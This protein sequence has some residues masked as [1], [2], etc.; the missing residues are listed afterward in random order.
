MRNTAFRRLVRS[1]PT[2]LALA[3]ALAAAGSFIAPGVSLAEVVISP[4]VGV[5]APDA[6]AGVKGCYRLD[7]TIYGPY[8]MS[9]CLGG[10][11]NT[12]QVIGGGLNCAGNLDWYDRKDGKI[13]VDLHRTP[14]GK[15]QQWTGDSLTCKI[16]N[17]KPIVKT[18]GVQVAVPVQNY[19]T[20]NCNY[21][22]VA[23][24]Y[25]PVHVTATRI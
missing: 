15:N 16:N 22:P 7:T 2:T 3:T 21:N 23:G 6:S 19:N 12:Y 13:E 24:G 8:R 11:N 5:P 1:A 9:F 17:W 4:L 20:M 25:K 18:P 10:H 14:C